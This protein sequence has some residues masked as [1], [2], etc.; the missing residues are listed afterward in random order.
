MI[1]PSQDHLIVTVNEVDKISKRGV[2]IE[3]MII[4]PEIKIDN[5]NIEIT[6]VAIVMTGGKMNSLEVRTS[7]PNRTV[8]SPPSQRLD[9][10]SLLMMMSMRLLPNRVIRIWM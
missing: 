2:T 6:T 8:F 4:L 3:N 5:T 1:P 9:Q 10:P 7:R